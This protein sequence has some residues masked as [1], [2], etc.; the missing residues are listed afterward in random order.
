MEFLDTNW[1]H[2]NPVLYLNPCLVIFWYLWWRVYYWC[3]RHGLCRRYDPTQQT[4]TIRRHTKLECDHNTRKQRHSYL[5]Y[6]WKLQK[7]DM[8]MPPNTLEDGGVNEL[9][10]A[11]TVDASFTTE[12]A[13]S[14]SLGTHRTRSS[15]SNTE[16]ISNMIWVNSGVVSLIVLKRGSSIAP[17]HRTLRTLSSI[18]SIHLCSRSRKIAARAA[19]TQ[20]SSSPVGDAGLGWQDNVRSKTHRWNRGTYWARWGSTNCRILVPL[21]DACGLRLVARQK[22]GHGDASRYS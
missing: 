15:N 4:T 14:G 13:A 21:T 9:F 19:H 18:C 22:A 10:V 17:M 20:G 1:S 7:L 12:H 3:W 16:S 5:L 11:V 6:V 8:E 2:L